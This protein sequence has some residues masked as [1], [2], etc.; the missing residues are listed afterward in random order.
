MNLKIV[1]IVVVVLVITGMLALV[2]PVRQRAGESHGLK[3]IEEN[4]KL[5]EDLRRMDAVADGNLRA[6]I[7]VA[8]FFERIN[9]PV[10]L[11]A[12]DPF[13]TPVPQNPGADGPPGGEPPAAPEP[14]P[15][16]VM[17]LP[18][19]TLHGVAVAGE[20]SLA[21]INYE[22]FRL[23]DVVSGLKLV[24][25]TEDGVELVSADARVSKTLTLEGW[26]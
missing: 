6:S 11:S 2:W 13:A 7:A 23:G 25:I 1:A 24:R 21:V 5:A 20:A 16:L 15:P 12:P 9:R 17:D 8:R 19:M 3:Q 18:P 4:V 10:V 22:V 26:E 14:E